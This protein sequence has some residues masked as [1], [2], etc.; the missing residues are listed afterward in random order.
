MKLNIHSLPVNF[1]SYPVVFHE[2]KYAAKNFLSEKRKNL[3]TLF[4]ISVFRA[5]V[6]LSQSVVYEDFEGNK[7]LHYGERTGVLDTVFKNPAPNEVNSSEKCALYI[8]NGSKKFDN[9][10]M[11]L[12]KNLSDVSPYA[13]YVG[14]P[15]RLKIKVN[16][17]DP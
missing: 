8:R 16:P 5:S 14:I 7:L 3:G 17:Q 12:S 10:K 1:K 11:K 13:T 15:P 6:V 4:L 2:I 9:I